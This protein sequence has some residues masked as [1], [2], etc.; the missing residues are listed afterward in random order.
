[1]IFSSLKVVQ[2]MLAKHDKNGRAITTLE[3]AVVTLKSLGVTTNDEARRVILKSNSMLTT[4]SSLQ[5]TTQS[6]ATS[7]VDFAS[8]TTQLTDLK[9]RADV[10]YTQ[11]RQTISV[12]SVTWGS[13]HKAILATINL[14][15]LWLII[16]LPALISTSVP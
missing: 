4:A 10:T 5:N 8:L 6:L 12:K 1:M 9:S 14:S 11:V 16:R 2:S 13:F 15:Y 3:G 7:D